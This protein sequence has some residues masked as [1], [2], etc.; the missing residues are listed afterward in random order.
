MD[1]M[2]FLTVTDER[3]HLP[4]REWPHDPH[5]Y[6]GNYDDLLWM[7]EH[8]PSASELIVLGLSIQHLQHVTLFPQLEKLYL[9]GIYHTGISEDS[10]Q[11]F[12][13]LSKIRTLKYL[14]IHDCRYFDDT[15]L[16]HILRLKGLK[17]LSI[18]S[19]LD[20]ISSY[21]PLRRLRQLEV[22]EVGLLQNM[23]VRRTVPDVPK[24]IIQPED[25]NC[26]HTRFH[27]L[28]AEFMTAQTI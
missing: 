22:L 10:I 1:T 6:C 4:I 25:G 5:E 20:T 12:S 26:Y 27:E 13:A 14:A 8:D 21:T 11:N 9:G 15:Q 28:V 7:H 17:I 2:D 19:F 16:R 24:L 23:K 3:L 18:T